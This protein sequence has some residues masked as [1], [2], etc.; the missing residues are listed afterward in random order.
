[1]TVSTPTISATP[2]LPSA[3][4]RRSRRPWSADLRLSGLLRRQFF[5]RLIKCPRFV[6]VMVRRERRA[7]FE[8]LAMPAVRAFVITGYRNGVAA[9][10]KDFSHAA[11]VPNA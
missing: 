2:R 9:L 7:A 1:M 8:L 11:L 4:F 10:C 5:R 3:R 6:W